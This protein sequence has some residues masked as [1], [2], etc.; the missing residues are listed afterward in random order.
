MSEPIFHLALPEDWD[1]AQQAGAYTMSTRG[2]AL[3]DVG[4]VHCSTRAQLVG[5]ADRFYA[6]VD[7]LYVL[8]VD[9]TRV[10]AEI[11]FEPPAPGVEELFPHLYGPLPLDAVIDVR[12]WQRTGERWSDT[13]R[14]GV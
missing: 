10:P 1:R 4:F 7:A 9:P 12:R 14:P 5:V 11:R 2:L 3:D 6:D 8:T 13:P